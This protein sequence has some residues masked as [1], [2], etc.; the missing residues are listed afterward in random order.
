M[1]INS[2]LFLFS[3]LCWL[4]LYVL[5]LSIRSFIKER[6]EKVYLSGVMREEQEPETCPFVGSM[7]LMG[8]ISLYAIYQSDFLRSFVFGVPLN[9]NSLSP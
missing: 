8:Y 4:S 2:A 5:T 9:R 3:K 1:I 6:E 7:W